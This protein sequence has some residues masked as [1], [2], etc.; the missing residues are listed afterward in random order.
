L[1]GLQ[2]LLGWFMVKSGLVN[3]PYVDHYRLAIHLLAA[4]L[5]FGYIF[6]IALDLM[7]ER[8]RV[9]QPRWHIFNEKAKVLKKLLFI[10][11]AFLIV[12]IIYGAFVA[13][14]KAGHVYNTF[15]KMDDQWIAEGITAMEPVWKNFVNG[16]AGVQ[17]V[18]RY[19]AYVIVIL[20]VVI[21]VKSHKIKLS[22]SQKTGVNAMAIMVIIQFLL[23]VFTL[24]FAVPVILAV[25]HQIGA[26]LLFASIIF[27]IHQLKK[28][29]SYA[30]HKTVSLPGPAGRLTKT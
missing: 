4:M 8:Y 20:V 15:P 29:N 18:H 5:L 1:G 24:L 28:F 2:G 22:F 30:D 17:F 27:F 12:Q 11:L 21:W 23:G 9:L 16:I 14:L 3:V 10:L 6:W 13:G 26:L 7:E 25:L 19:I